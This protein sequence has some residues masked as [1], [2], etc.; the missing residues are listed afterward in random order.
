MAESSNDMNSSPDADVP[1]SGLPENL[2]VTVGGCVLLIGLSLFF[3]YDG[4]VVGL[5]PLGAAFLIKAVLKGLVVLA[6]AAYVF[7]VRSDVPGMLGARQRI[8]ERPGDVVWVFEK[9]VTARG[10]VSRFLSV[11][12][13]NGKIVEWT[14]TAPLIEQPRIRTWIEQHLSHATIGYNDELRARFTRSPRDLLRS[15]PRIDAG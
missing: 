4:V 15:Q 9:V 13:I 12:F 6:F 5:G 3:F 11:G 1:W 14:L 2:V 8:R 7:F 10:S